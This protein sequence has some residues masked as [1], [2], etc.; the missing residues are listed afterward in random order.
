MRKTPVITATI[1]LLLA[2][3]LGAAEQPFLTT[4]PAAIIAMVPPPPANDSPAGMADLET[5]L[6]VQKDRT[7]AQ[8]ARAERVSAHDSLSMGAQV[9]GPAFNEKNLPRTI[10]ILTKAT[11]ERRPVVHASKRQWNRTRPY[12]RGLGVEPCVKRQDN[13][14]Y[15]SGHSA[16]SALWAVLLGKAM[17]EYEILF[18]DDVRETMWCR[19]IGGVHYPSDTQA[20]KLIGTII[21][22]EMLRNKQ[23]RDAIKE[24]RDELLDFLK[25]NPDAKKRAQTLL[26]K[27]ASK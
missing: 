19:V 9:F 1:A 6:Q 22:N 13:T 20:G 17:P 27:T 18:M 10:A 24:M 21:A 14:S 4:D 3:T 23:T 16:A 12:D 11:N 15:P 2:A 26:E 7:P 8:A 5:V 25:K